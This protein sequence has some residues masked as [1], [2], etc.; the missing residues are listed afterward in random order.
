M[1][2]ESRSGLAVLTL[3]LVLA[4]AGCGGAQ[5]LEK[6]QEGSAQAVVTMPQELSASD[7][8]RVELTVSGAGMTTR[9]DA[10]VKTAGQWGGVLGQLPAGTGRTFRAEAFDASN[11]VRYAGQVA[12]VTIVANQT[13]ALSLRL[14]E[15]NAPPPFANSAPRIL[16]LV[17]SPSTVAPGGQVTLQATA[18]DPNAGDTLTYAWTAPSGS[19]GAAS[20]LSTSWTAPSTPGQVT[21][22]LTVTD[23]KGAS[24][25]LSVIITVSTGNGGAAVNVTFNTWPQVTRMTALPSSVAV[26][27]STQLTVTATDSDN[28]NLSYEWVASC[29]GTWTNAT[30]ASPTFTP[31]AV[32]PGGTCTLS[33]AARDGR[34]GMGIGSLTLY[35]SATPTTGQFPPEIVE[36]FQSVASIPAQGNTVVFRAKARDPQGSALTFSWTTSTGTLGTATDTATT[37]EVIWTGPTCVP[38]GNP[39]TVTVTVTNALGLS[40]AYVF[41]LQGGT[42]CN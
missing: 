10:L 35:V 19:F 34:G 38:A 27:Q 25:S 42:A 12:P 33:V 31:T 36:T 15:V 28:D 21:L 23:S 2:R 11:T 4:L 29:T 8:T 16:S 26:G 41:S 32:P 30:S 37:S 22:T 5:E 24:A 40:T 20:S 1:S 18:D 6:A 9:T 3:G 39:R 17:A 13:T 14:Q 7:V